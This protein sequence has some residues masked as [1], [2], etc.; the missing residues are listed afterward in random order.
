MAQIERT[1][2]IA[3]ARKQKRFWN[4]NGESSWGHDWENYERD[5]LRL[6]DSSHWK[7]VP[8]PTNPGDHQCSS[9][10]Y[11]RP[12][13]FQGVSIEGTCKDKIVLVKD[14][15]RK[16]GTRR[17]PAI[18]KQFYLNRKEYGQFMTYKVK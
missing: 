10:H 11:R 15:V 17:G 2:Q 13:S 18:L 16:V 7:S 5:L 3:F 1:I 14:T 6:K 9:N 12:G 4:A 8:V